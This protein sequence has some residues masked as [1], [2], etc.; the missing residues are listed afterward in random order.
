M[1]LYDEVMYARIDILYGQIYVDSHIRP[2]LESVS[3][4]SCSSR[5]REDCE[6]PYLPDLDKVRPSK[7]VRSGGRSRPSLNI[8]CVRVH[9]RVHVRV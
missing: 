2:L 6:T 8:L 1:I 5:L 3:F 4:E 7:S 9:V